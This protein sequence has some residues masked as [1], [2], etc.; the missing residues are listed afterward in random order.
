MWF[1]LGSRA[2]WKARVDPDFKKVAKRMEGRRLALDAG[3]PPTNNAFIMRIGDAVVVEFGAT[4]NACYVFDAHNL[5]FTLDRPSI[6]GDTGGLKHSAHSERLLH[7][8]ASGQSWEERFDAAIFRAIQWTPVEAPFRLTHRRPP[9]S[10]VELRRLATAH[11]LRIEDNRPRGGALWVRTDDANTTVSAVLRA[12]NF[13][14]K[15]DR[16]WYRE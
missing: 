5:P 4:G 14:Y 12:W 3:G 2:Q 15:R 16:G 11:G 9:F 6:R 13:T 1:A 7:G 8:T 10:D